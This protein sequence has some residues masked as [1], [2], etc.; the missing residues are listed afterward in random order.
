[1][2]GSGWG[3]AGAKGDWYANRDF[4]MCNLRVQK[5]EKLP[6]AWQIPQN[7]R[8][9]KEQY[10]ENCIAYKPPSEASRKAPDVDRDAEDAWVP[11]RKGGQNKSRAVK[12]A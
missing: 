11:S 5:G 6:D 1:M 2:A 9:L 8:Y 4:D 12:A 10:G 3:A 7:A